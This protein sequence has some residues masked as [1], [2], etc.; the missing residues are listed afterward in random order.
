MCGIAGFYGFFNEAL[1]DGMV[2]A[3]A[4]RG[5]DDQGSVF[6][7]EQNGCIGLGHRRLSIIDLSSEGRQPMSVDCP[8]CGVSTPEPAGKKLWLVYNGE[9][10]NYKE[11]RA[12]LAARGHHFHSR[13]DS[14][15]LLHLYTEKGLDMLALLN[16]IFAFAIYDGRENGLPDGMQPKNIF[17]ARDGLGVKPLYYCEQESGFL[18]ASELKALL[19]YSQLPRE[20]DFTA[21]HYYLAYLWSPAP[22][23]PLKQVKK[24]R[25]GEAFIVREGRIVR[26]WSF[27][28]LPYGQN[29]SRKS[30]TRIAEELNQYLEQAVERQ[31][32]ADVP[33]GAFLSGGLDSSAVVAMM[34][35]VRPNHRPTC[36]VIGFNDILDMDGSPQDLPYASRV[37][38]HLNVNLQTI[39]VQPD[40][41]ENLERM[42]YYLDEP[43]ADPAPINV[44]LI[45]E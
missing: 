23:T 43:Q 16:G 18:F 5:P 24:A 11:L 25:P 32:V 26:K 29:W 42:L 28:D 35:K 14:E 45:A 13:S 21:L 37:A 10:Y 7:K 6:W 33:V 22:H 36:Y 3:I 9:I 2:A 31:M 1:L 41:I 39:E 44:L 27:Y 30:E 8:L 20:L 38:R 12:E 4:H 17:L 40:M 34:R 15:V 19:Q